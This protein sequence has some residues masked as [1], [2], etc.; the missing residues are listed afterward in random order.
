MNGG[1]KWVSVDSDYFILEDVPHYLQ[2]FPILADAEVSGKGMFSVVFQKAP[3]S[4]TVY[5]MTCDDA[6]VEFMQAHAGTPG[7]PAFAKLLG[8][9]TDLEGKV[10]YLIEL[11]R[12]SALPEEMHLEREAVIATV[13]HRI[14]ESE[15]FNGIIECQK[16]HADALKEVATSP[17]FSKPIRAALLAISEFL[18][19]TTRDVLVD[20]INRENFMY[21]GFGMIITD[22]IAPVD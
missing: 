21:D 4:P 5:K 16:C 19:A 12:L 1:T 8:T 15:K 6:Y 10:V 20:L 7:L 2:A 14:M 11:P 3:N 13:S 18:A 22:P 17:L 9:T